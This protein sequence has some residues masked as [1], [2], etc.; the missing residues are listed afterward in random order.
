VNAISQA[1]MFCNRV[2]SSGGYGPLGMWADVE[3]QYGVAAGTFM[4][5][6]ASFMYEVKKRMMS[7]G[8]GNL[9]LGIYTR[10]SFID[11]IWSAAGRPAWIREFPCWQAYYI[12]GWSNYQAIYDDIV[13]DNFA[14]PPPNPPLC[15]PHRVW[16]Q[17]TH[18]GHPEDVPGYPEYK[19]SIDFNIAFEWPVTVV[20]PEPPPTTTLAMRV[21]HNMNIRAGA[22]TNFMDIGDLVAGQ[23]VQVSDVDGTDAWVK[24]GDGKYSAV[25]TNGSRYMEPA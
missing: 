14:P 18:K 25:E 1:A 21:L 17:W 15:M 12:T 7:A 8:A 22:G 19:L 5:R 6:L 13:H 16:W 9:W 23:I 4:T 3:Y 2:E 20:V 11:P 24:I 10:S